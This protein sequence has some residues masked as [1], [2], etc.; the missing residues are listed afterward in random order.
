[1][2]RTLIA[3]VVVAA[4][5][6][7]AAVEGLQKARVVSIKEHPQGRIVH[8]EGRV[9]IFDG[10]P[11]YDITLSWKGKKYV[12]RYE[13]LSGYFPKAWEIGK[14]I[15]VKRERGCFILYRG[16]EAVPAREVDPDDCV[17]ASSPA[18]GSM[19]QIPCE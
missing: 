3:I 9:P 4:A 8:W 15:Q 10:H 1:M 14:D 19:P 12:V 6:I 5:F 18:A 7:V 11:A 16:D 2:K 17:P 13:S